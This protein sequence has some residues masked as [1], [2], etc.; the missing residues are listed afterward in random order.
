[1]DREFQKEFMEKWKKYFKKADLPVAFFYSDDEKYGDYLKPVDKQTCMIGQLAVARKGQTLAF[2]QETFGCF[3]GRRYSGYPTEE[4]AEFK[5]FLS[6][7]I[8][9]ELEGE[10]YKKTPELVEQY[11]KDMP[12]PPAE[13]KCIVF[14]RWDKLEDGDE[15][16]VVIFF[17][18]PDVLS[19]LF[20]LANFRT[21]DPQAVIAPFCSGCGSIISYPLAERKS[22][23]PRAVVGMFDVSARPFVKENLLSFAAP[24]KKFMQ[25]VEDMDESFLITNSWKKV[26]R[27]IEKGK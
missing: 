22:Q 2:T 17:A 3:G 26:S 13:G 20:T 16:L 1:M 25:M 6:C 9:G 24:M 10:R 15:P 8:P 21:L 5:Y 12:T 11:V 19:G 4:W 18:P 14:K 27:R 7:G 23:N